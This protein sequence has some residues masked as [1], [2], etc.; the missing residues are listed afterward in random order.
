MII[1]GIDTSCDETSVAVCQDGKI[2]SNKIWSQ[3]ILHSKFGGVYPTLAKREHQDKI[4]FVIKKAL[5]QAKIKLEDIDAIAVTIGPGLAP[6]LEVGIAKAKELAKKYKKPVYSINHLEG[7]ILSPFVSSSNKWSVSKIKSMFPAFGLV[8]S[9]GNTIFVYAEKIGKYKVLAETIDDA[10]GEALDKGAR[11]LGLGYPGGA[12]LEKIAK[13]KE[14]GTK[15]KNPLPLP[16]AQEKQNTKI[17]YSGLKTALVRLVEKTESQ[18][19]S[20]SKKDII[21][22]SYFYQDRAFTHLIRTIE[23]LFDLY[24]A[25]TFLVGGGVAANLEIRK[26]LRKIAKEK[27]IKIMFPESKKICGDNAAMIAYTAYIKKTIEKIK[28]NKLNKLERVPNLK[29]Q[30]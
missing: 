13:L 22:L 2:L 5:D 24:K 8:I 12:V 4:D 15:E 29:I 9:G 17:S 27:R 28:P 7:H 3:A 18:K 25:K 20:L 1:L 16:F 11:L 14:K 6:A 10:I 23:P 26:R 21:D 30:R 19:G